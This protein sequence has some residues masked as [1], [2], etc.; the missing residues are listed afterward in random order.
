[1]TFG[2]RIRELRLQ[3]DMPQRELAQLIEIDFTYLSKIE[4]DKVPPPSDEVILKLAEHLHTSEEELLT[5]AAKVDADELR[6]AVARDPR[7]G[8]LFRKL[9]S[10]ELTNDQVGRMMEIATGDEERS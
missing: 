5:L 3:K 10:R 6:E 9:Q 4:N 1:M 8:V 7:I 2:E